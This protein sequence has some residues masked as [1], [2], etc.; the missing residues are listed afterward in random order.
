MYNSGRGKTNKVAYKGL[1]LRCFLQIC[2]F[3]QKCFFYR[4]DLLFI[5]RCIFLRRDEF[6]QLPALVIDFLRHLEIIKNKSELTVLE[7][8]SDLRMFFR[9]ILKIRCLTKCENF[10]DI[11]ISEIDLTFIKTITLNDAYEFIVFCKTERHNNE[12]AQEKFHLLKRFL[13]IS[14]FR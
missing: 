8:A 7:Y 14:P 1:I 4:L 6:D 10:E 9:F 5:W 12:L 3:L 11:D 2:V 13:N